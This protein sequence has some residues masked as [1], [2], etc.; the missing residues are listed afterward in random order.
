MLKLESGSFVKITSEVP[1]LPCLHVGNVYEVKHKPY[2]LHVPG[3][4]LIHRTGKLV[5]RSTLEKLKLSKHSRQSATAF[6]LDDRN[7]WRD[8]GTLCTIGVFD[9]TNINELTTEVKVVSPVTGFSKAKYEVVWCLTVLEY[10]PGSKPD[11]LLIGAIEAGSLDIPVCMLAGYAEVCSPTQSSN[12]HND[13][14]TST[15]STSSNDKNN[16][17]P[18]PQ[19]QPASI[20]SDKVPPRQTAKPYTVNKPAPVPPPQGP[21]ELPKAELDAK[22]VAAAKDNDKQYTNPVHVAV[23]I[24]PVMSAVHS[25]NANI[26]GVVGVIRNIEPGKGKVALLSGFQDEGELLQHTIR[27]EFKEEIGTLKSALDG[28][29]HSQWT[30]YKEY[31]T[32]SGRSLDAFIHSGITLEEFEKLQKEFKPNSEVSGLTMISFGSALAFPIHEQMVKAFYQEPFCLWN[33]TLREKAFKNFMRG[34]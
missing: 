1:G 6:V 15:V 21:A 31:M 14:G 19:K 7:L 23:G 27:R 12:A 34:R 25:L 18:A 11:S 24:I 16:A 3:N 17:M 10:G 28:K 30:Y 8:L 32:P 13:K 29:D 33:P 9:K 26:L 20:A 4:C 2:L 22:K 5:A